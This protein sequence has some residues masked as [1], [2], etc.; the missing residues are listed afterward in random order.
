MNTTIIWFRQDLR[1]TDNPAFYHAIKESETVLPVYIDDTN[2]PS[3][4]RPGGASQWWLHQSLTHLAESLAKHG[5]PLV[6]RR[7]N[8]KEILF[9]LLKEAQATAVYWN[10]CYEPYAIARDKK[11]KAEL[12][13]MGIK[14]QTYNA[15]LLFEPWEITNKEGNYFKVFT[16]FWQTC[17]KKP[18][19]DRP[20][21]APNFNR[22]NKLILPSE[23]LA[24]WHL[25]PTQP[26]WSGG[27][28]AH[29][30]PGE[31]YAKQ[32][33]Q[34]F[35]R[36]H[37]GHYAQAR[38]FPS[39]TGTS[40]LSP[41]LHFGEISPRQIWHATQQALANQ[42]S[43][44]G[45]IEKFLSELGWRE[46]SYHLLYH[47]PSLAEQPFRPEFA[48]FPWHNQQKQLKAW[49][50]GKTGYPI[51]DAGMRELWHTGWMH[52]RVRMLVASFLTKDLFIPWQIGEAWFWDTLVDADLANNAASWQ[53]VAGCGA[54]AAPYFRIFNPS[55]QS[56][57]FDPSGKYI[58]QW[59]PELGHLPNEYVHQPAAAPAE[60][61]SKAKITLGKDYPYPIVDHDVRRKEALAIFQALRKK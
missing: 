58:K 57:K 60:V 21:P 8:A 39:L 27:I 47:F 13:T 2:V 5:L 31:Q 25:L 19:P 26:D 11:I 32:Q 56:M 16:R 15:S 51:I 61:L 35:L 33:L 43:L 36:H 23:K 44:A 46:F 38:D 12:Q 29:W 18:S 1:L 14:T 42:G 40:K 54:D 4:W 49:Q 41:Y 53:W 20:L 55:L 10:R 48:D 22:E 7:G 30:R 28:A 34:N 24:D 9:A 3:R 50:Q 45:N 6:L 59:L 37:V 52:N 17:L